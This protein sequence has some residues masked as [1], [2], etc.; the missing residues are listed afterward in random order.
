M[1]KK[2]PWYRQLSFWVVAPA[3]VIAIVTYRQAW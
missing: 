1:K 3:A 2:I